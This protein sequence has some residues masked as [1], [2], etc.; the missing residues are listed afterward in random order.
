MEWF[1]MM[2]VA[3]RHLLLDDAFDA[4]RHGG[5]DREHERGADHLVVGC[6]FPA[7]L[8]IKVMDWPG[9]R[10]GVACS[11]TTVANKLA[12][13]IDVMSLGLED[14]LKACSRAYSILRS[15]PSR[16]L[17][18]F[19]AQTRSMPAATEVERIAIQRVGQDIFRLALEDFWGGCCPLTGIKDR[20]LLRASHIVPWASCESDEDRLDV[21]NGFLLAA[22]I[23]AA[24]DRH[25]V[26]IDPS[27]QLLFAPSISSR[28]QEMIKVSL[29]ADK[30][31]L[32]P[33]HE[34]FL[35]KHRAKIMASAPDAEIG[36]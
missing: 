6:E 30:L 23:D 18:A 16:P 36:A 33:Q 11:D 31:K 28:G 21:F 22:H 5:F 12:D 15:V 35:V 9:G 2:D 10:Y 32:E 4:A 34:R 7:S 14:L 13:E 20:A 19:K 26:T 29:I 24:F 17:E 1:R 27:G 25:L 3:R 8:T